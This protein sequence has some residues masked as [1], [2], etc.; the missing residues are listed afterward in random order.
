MADAAALP[1]QRPSCGWVSLF[2]ACASSFV[3]GAF[4]AVSS[5]RAAPHMGFVSSGEQ[6]PSG[7]RGPSARLS[8]YSSFE[9]SAGSQRFGNLTLTTTQRVRFPKADDMAFRTCVFRDVCLVN[10]A[11]TYYDDPD[12]AATTPPGMRISD[13]DAAH[14]HMFFRG[15]FAERLGQPYAPTVVS[16]PR[17]ASYFMMPA[18]RFY[19]LNELSYAMNFGHLL[20]DSI[21]PAYSVA[22]VLG[23]DIANVQLVGVVSCSTLQLQPLNGPDACRVNMERW[24]APLFDHPYLLPPFSEPLCFRR[25][26]AGQFYTLSHMYHHRSQAIRAA[27]AHLHSALGVPLTKQITSHHVVVQLKH[28]QAAWV[29]YSTVCS[30]VRA[31]AA[32]FTPQPAV[33]CLVSA[34]VSVREQLELIANATVT[35]AEHGS[36]NYLSL[37]QPPGSSLLMIVTSGEAKEAQV[38]LYNTDVQA[39]YLSL[40][41]VRRRGEGPGALRLALERAGIRLGLPMVRMKA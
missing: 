15:Y 34:D 29:E 20:I 11:L 25:L 16:G 7:W 36:T 39:F 9:C 21:L 30:D 10:G 14:G 37:F 8:N 23:E 31:W 41:A 24:M 33:T 40:D 13:F 3:A 27:R 6:P 38:F 18:E 35:V 22:Q 28:V 4:L 1:L 17:P 19:I 26:V 2:L 5:A 12:L 32:T